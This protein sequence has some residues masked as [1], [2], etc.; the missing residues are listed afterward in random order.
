MWSSIPILGSIGALLVTRKKIPKYCYETK[1]SESPCTTPHLIDG[2]FCLSVQI[3]DN[4]TCKPMKTVTIVP[5]RASKTAK[6]VVA[7]NPP[8][9]SQPAGVSVYPDQK[10]R[11]RCTCLSQ[12]PFSGDVCTDLS[13][14]PTYSGELYVEI[15]GGAG[16]DHLWYDGL[17]NAVHHTGGQSGR[18]FGTL[19]VSPSDTLRVQFGTSATATTPLDLVTGSLPQVP[20]G[21]GLGTLL[22]GGSGGG[23]TVVSQNKTIVLVAAGGGGASKNANGG[24]AGCSD[25]LS[26]LTS[27]TLSVNGRV[28]FL[29]IIQQIPETLYLSG[30]GATSGAP[31]KTKDPYGQ[32]SSLQGGTATESLSAGGGGGSGYYGGS[33]GFTNAKSKPNNTHGAGGG[34]SCYAHPRAFYNSFQGTRY[35]NQDSSV[36]D[37]KKFPRNTYVTFGFPTSS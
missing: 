19:L 7:P 11:L 34:G 28:G 6:S 24:D 9:Q 1:I 3:A 14:V 18:A 10:P 35:T 23:A 12:G 27:T 2:S 36:V 20:L 22:A 31:G 37:S 26:L 16:A 13:C 5:S 4:D 17:G 8:T 32:G 30:G 25:D 29:N 21:G 15:A 33:S